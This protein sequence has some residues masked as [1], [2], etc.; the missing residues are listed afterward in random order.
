MPLLTV[1]AAAAY[2]ISAASIIGSVF[3]GVSWV[4]DTFVTHSEMQMMFVELRSHQVEYAIR[5][6]HKEGIDTLNADDRYDYNQLLKAAE[7]IEDQRN[8]LLGLTNN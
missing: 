3:I 1:K 6:F 4:Q 7:K 5:D 8:A 2:I